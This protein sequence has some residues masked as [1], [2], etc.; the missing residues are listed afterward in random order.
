VIIVGVLMEEEMKSFE[1]KVGWSGHR[2]DWPM[3]FKLFG[4]CCLPDNP[5]ML[6]NIVTSLVILLVQWNRVH[7]F[8]K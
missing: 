2:L 6:F 8:G 7:I 1:D 5:S 3:Q 4:I